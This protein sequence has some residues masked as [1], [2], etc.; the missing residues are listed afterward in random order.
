MDLQQI[1]FKLFFF[2][3]IIVIGSSTSIAIIS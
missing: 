2:I 1:V 3:I